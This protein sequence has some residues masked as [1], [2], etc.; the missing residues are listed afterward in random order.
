[1]CIKYFQRMKDLDDDWSLLDKR[2]SNLVSKK[3]EKMYSSINSLDTLIL[4][5]D[6]TKHSELYDIH[7][8]V[9]SHTVNTE[10]ELKYDYLETNNN[11][12]KFNHVFMDEQTL[13]NNMNKDYFEKNIV[14][15]VPKLDNDSDTIQNLKINNICKK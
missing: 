8:D 15:M 14:A 2:S 6:D 5:V 12:T 3:T 13:C 7:N 9:Y 4:E 1:M 10:T 11:D